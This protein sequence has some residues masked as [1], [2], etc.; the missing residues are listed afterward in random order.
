MASA[1]PAPEMEPA[2]RPPYLL[3]RT[4]RQ[5]A[6]TIAGCV[7]VLCSV[8]VIAGDQGMGMGLGGVGLAVTRLQSAGSVWAALGT[9]DANTV[10]RTVRDTK[11]TAAVETPPPSAAAEA[12]PAAEERGLENPAAAQLTASEM[13]RC[14]IAVSPKHESFRA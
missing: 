3:S 7:L 10:K 2:Q 9:V 11:L 5:P 1:D 6:A 12:P 14:P 13:V 4:C 8:A